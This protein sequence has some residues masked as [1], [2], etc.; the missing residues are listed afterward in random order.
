MNIRCPLCHAWWIFE[1]LATIAKMSDVPGSYKGVFAGNEFWRIETTMWG[2]HALCGECSAK[3]R[4]FMVPEGL[5][6]VPARVW[7]ESDEKTMWGRLKGQQQDYAALLRA[8]PH[9]G[10]PMQDDQK[11]VR[12]RILQKGS[13]VISRERCKN[14]KL[15]WGTVE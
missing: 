8:R 2:Q 15:G 10:K 11:N 3:H 9:D 6:R 5:F 14:L 4:A 13:I 7:T 1:F 12:E